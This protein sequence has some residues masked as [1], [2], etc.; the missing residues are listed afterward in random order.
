[1]QHCIRAP[2]ALIL[3]ACAYLIC[4]ASSVAYAQGATPAAPPPAPA[5][6]LGHPLV[7]QLFAWLGM[8]ATA[9]TTLG[10]ILPKGWRFTQL[11]A[12]FSTDLRGILTPDPADDPS[13]TKPRGRD[14][15]ALIV[16]AV[17]LL[18]G[19]GFFR[20]SVAPAVAECAPDR[21]YLI[22][23]LSSI[24]DGANAFDVLDRIKTEKGA[25]FVTCALTRFL[26]RVAVSPETANQRT[27]ARAYLERE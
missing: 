21:H 4:F 11:L 7:D 17:L 3:F 10:T 25:E 2:L 6:M 9:T 1:M 18:P 5:P 20:D 15:S 22:D 24:L 23:G 26:D 12:R 8:L 14:S 13:W 19:C 27:V 16:F